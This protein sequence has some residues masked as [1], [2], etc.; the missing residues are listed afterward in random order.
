ME[1]NWRSLNLNR[2]EMLTWVIVFLIVVFVA[3]IFAFTG[4]VKGLASLAKIIFYLFLTLLAI[5]LIIGVVS[6]F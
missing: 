4:L 2:M 5:A 1:N 3:A 6:G